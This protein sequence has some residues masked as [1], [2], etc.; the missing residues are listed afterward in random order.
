[1]QFFKLFFKVIIFLAVFFPGTILAQENNPGTK[2]LVGISVDQSVFAFDLNPGEKQSFKIKLKNTSDQ[3]QQMSAIREDFSVSDN[4]ATNLLDGKNEIYGMKDWISTSEKDW[5]LEAGENKELVF[6]FEVP[7]DAS[8]GSHFSSVL[9]RSFPAI[10]GVNFEH[11]LISGQ[12]GIYVLVNVKGQV[13]GKGKITKFE[14]P[15]FGDKSIAFKT[16]F[17][18]DGSV[19]YIPHGEISIKNILTGRSDKVDIE[20]HFVFPGKKYSF[21]SE[22]SIPSVL[23]IYI[24][25]A[26]FVD[27]DNARHSQKRI[28]FGKYS[29]FTILIIVFLMLA[30]GRLFH[31]KYA[32][33]EEK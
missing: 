3:K 8:V 10:T 11:T 31:R 17:E 24:A 6:Q 13:S 29:A 26:S 23:G 27:G 2:D 14:A 1:M 18:N 19:H 33:K 5:F 12:V 22:G 21:D 25:N 16:E 28:I 9:I 20:K 32:K 30:L 7:K 4:N 15:I